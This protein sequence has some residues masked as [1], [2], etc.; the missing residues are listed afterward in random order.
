MRVF[1]NDEIETIL[2]GSM[3]QRRADYQLAQENFNRTVNEI[4]SGLPN[5]DGVQNIHNAAA[6]DN[7]ALRSYR[8]ALSEFTEFAVNGI[9][10]DRFN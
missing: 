2:K 3:D 6:A 8:E 5:P 7:F 1:T 4:P 9:V 10:P